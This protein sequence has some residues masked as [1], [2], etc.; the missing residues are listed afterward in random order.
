M[1]KTF[2]K[3]CCP[4]VLDF[5]EGLVRHR[6]IQGSEDGHTLSLWAQSYPTELVD[7]LVHIVKSTCSVCGGHQ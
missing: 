7:A 3:R 2:N 4:Q 5:G 1:E 6:V